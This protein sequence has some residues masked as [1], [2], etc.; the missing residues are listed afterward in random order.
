MRPIFCAMGRLVFPALSEWSCSVVKEVLP[1]GREGI[2]GSIEW[3]VD[4]HSQ[5]LSHSLG[6]LILLCHSY[7]SSPPPSCDERQTAK[8]NLERRWWWSVPPR[9]TSETEK[10]VKIDPRTSRNKMRKNKIGFTI[11]TTTIDLS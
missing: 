9:R 5:L 6:P 10:M 2:G 3:S 1:R 4:R 11:M 8:L 7:T